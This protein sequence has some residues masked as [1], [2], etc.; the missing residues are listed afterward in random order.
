MSFTHR[1]QSPFLPSINHP[2]RAK[3]L[4]WLI[5][6]KVWLHPATARIPKN[7]ED[8]FEPAEGAM[9][10]AGF[11]T[12]TSDK[13]EWEDTTYDDGS[14]QE[15]WSVEL[16]FVN[17]ANETIEDDEKLNT[18][19]RVWLEAGPW[20]DLQTEE[21]DNAPEG[22]FN[23]FNRW[24]RSHDYRLNCGGTDLI[25]AMLTLA[26]L[27]ELFYNDDGTDKGLWPCWFNDETELE[28]CEG[29]V[30]D[31]CPHCGF[32]NSPMEEEEDDE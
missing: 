11:L 5:D 9:G 3:R 22:G 6:H 31:F 18:A 21:P 17:P 15:C 12:L 20:Y 1:D 24:M 19:F 27:V 30:G 10:D 32:T 26:N 14:I 29:E 4:E 16:Q 2:D 28:A 13:V 23:E 25:E 8:A 7:F